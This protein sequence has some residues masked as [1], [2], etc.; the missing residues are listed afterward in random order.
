VNWLSLLLDPPR[1]TKHTGR[2]V[3]GTAGSIR[4][5]TEQEA[6]RKRER[7]PVPKK[8]AAKRRNWV[9]RLPYSPL[10]GGRLQGAHLG[11][12]VAPER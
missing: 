12:S 3:A 10:R 8:P 6:E 2:L 7:K 1:I 4:E 11:L 5:R 9:I